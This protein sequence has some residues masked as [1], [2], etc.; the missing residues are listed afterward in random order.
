MVVYLMKLTFEK[1]KE[2]KFL[3]PAFLSKT[4]TF[5]NLH[6]VM[7]RPYSCGESRG[8]SK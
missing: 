3:P 8:M 2:F 4:S 1:F 5:Q 6:L 7:T